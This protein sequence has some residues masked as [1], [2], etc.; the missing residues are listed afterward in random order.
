MR[1]LALVPFLYT[2]GTRFATPRALIYLIA[3]SWI[4]GIWILARLGGEGPA[5]AVLGYAAGFLAFISVY[6]IGYLVN[7][8]W[9]AA[10]GK[11]RRRVSFDAGPGFIALFAAIRIAVW[12]AIGALTGWILEPAWLI[13]Y[14]ALVL[15]VV[16]HNLVRPAALRPA[17]F[18]Q[19]AC[20][21]FTIPVLGGVATTQVPLV[22]LI[23][24]IFYTYFRFLSYLDSKDLLAMNE[25]RHPGFGFAQ[26]ALMAP[27]IAF[28]AYVSGEWIL[29]QLFGYFITLYGL[30]ALVGR[31]R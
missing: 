26:M 21:R 5:G 4:P 22:L 20:L 8:T 29:V 19:L 16:A 30:Y 17:T 23:S 15:A 27:F 28:V 6:E 11:T 1:R 14:G 31:S 18:F 13:A 7:D 12:G 3:S 2:I 24:V 25:R 9:D 10:R